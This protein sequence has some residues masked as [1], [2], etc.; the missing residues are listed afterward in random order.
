MAQLAEADRVDSTSF[1]GD[2]AERM[3]SL[4]NADFRD[5]VAVRRDQL[6]GL[7][8]TDIRFADCFATG[9]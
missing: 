7:M 5:F 2:L 6:L 3:R 1:F 9:T 4:G 8:R